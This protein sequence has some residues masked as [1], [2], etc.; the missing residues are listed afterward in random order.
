MQLE[1][2]AIWTNQ[3]ETLKDFYVRYFNA[4]SNSKYISDKGERGTFQSYFLSFT[5]G[6][7]LELMTLPTIPKGNSINGYEATGLTH[8]AFSAET[9][10]QLDVLYKRLKE[11]GAT[12]VSEPRMTGDGYYEVCVLDPDGNR[13]EITVVP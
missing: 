6:A 7:R 4:T 12:I 3:I 13:V 5:G 8:I 9:R 11:D 10:E 1:H 2:I